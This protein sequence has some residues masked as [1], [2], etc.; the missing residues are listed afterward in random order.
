MI[1]AILSVLLGVLSWLGA[2][3]VVP[4]IALA[5]GANAVV[6]ARRAEP[7]PRAQTILGALGIL[8]GG[9][10]TLAILLGTYA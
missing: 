4:V 3:I 2:P 6:K 5:L 9:A 7:R 1:S 8:L 10:A